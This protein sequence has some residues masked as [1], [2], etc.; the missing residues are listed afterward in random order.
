MRTTERQVGSYAGN[1]SERLFSGVEEAAAL[2]GVRTQRVSI[3]HD[4]RGTAIVAASQQ[5]RADLIVLGVVA[6]NIA[7]QT[8]LGQ[9]T[10]HVLRAA[11]AGVVVVAL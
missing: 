1:L 8:F 6:Q 5:N 2:A 10:E 11:T 4:S 3:A 9:T 7:G